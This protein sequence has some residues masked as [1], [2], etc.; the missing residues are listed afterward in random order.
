MGKGPRETTG[1]PRPEVLCVRA[2]SGAAKLGIPAGRCGRETPKRS[3]DIYPSV[4]DLKHKYEM[5]N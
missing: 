2:Q 5:S 1:L 4:G 3:M